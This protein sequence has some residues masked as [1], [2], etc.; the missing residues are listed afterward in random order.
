M[1][2]KNVPGKGRTSNLRL[3]RPTLY[4]IELR[5]QDHHEWEQTTS[6]FGLGPVER[7]YL[8]ALVP[9]IIDV[10]EVKTST[11]TKTL[12]PRS[13]RGNNPAAIPIGRRTRLAWFCQIEPV[14]LSN[15][16]LLP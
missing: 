2:V 9:V 1:R 10:L 7:E 6:R 13:I 8:I 16:K 12:K 5:E 3:R 14:V 11:Q 4:P 15:L